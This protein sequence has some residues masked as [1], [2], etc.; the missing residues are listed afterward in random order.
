MSLGAPGM[1]SKINPSG[2]MGPNS[3][4]LKMYYKYIIEE[5]W[6]NNFT[7]NNESSSIVNEQPSETINEIDDEFINSILKQ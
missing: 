3:M 4:S 7:N 2:K 6:F 1:D 5:A